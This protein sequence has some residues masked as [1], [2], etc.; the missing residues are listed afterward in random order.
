[1]KPNIITQTHCTYVSLITSVSN[2][3]HITLEENRSAREANIQECAT[4]RTREALATSICV[5]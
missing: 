4:Y 1:M 2:S 5:I 3:G